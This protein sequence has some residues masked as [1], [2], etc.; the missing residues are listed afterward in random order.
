M[1]Y[2]ESE[3]TN[4]QGDPKDTDYQAVYQKYYEK[5]EFDLEKAS[6]RL[7]FYY[8]VE[9]GG[10]ELEGLIAFYESKKKSQ[11]GTSAS[12]S[13]VETDSGDVTS[14]TVPQTKEKSGGAG[15]PTFKDLKWSIVKH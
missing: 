11:N 14:S 3:A 9:E 15:L 12:D 7:K 1:L 8:G 6:K 4:P 13:N 5:K 10:P 2:K